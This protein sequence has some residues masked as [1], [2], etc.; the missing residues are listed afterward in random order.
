MKIQIPVKTYKDRFIKYLTFVNPLL[1]LRDE[2]IQVLASYLTL[3]LKYKDYNEETLY[4]LLFSQETNTMIRANLKIS[5][6]SFN[7]SV[8][9]LK[10]KD[11]IQGSKFNPKILYSIIKDDYKIEISFK[12]S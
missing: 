1:H 12:E 3:Y 2:E 5:E 7:K 11:I 9:G 10:E 6:K 8:R 4:S